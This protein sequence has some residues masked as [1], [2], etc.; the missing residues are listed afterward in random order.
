VSEERTAGTDLG[1]RISADRSSRSHAPAAQ[2]PKP[3][4][5]E[6]FDLDAGWPMEKAAND[7]IPGLRCL[8]RRRTRLFDFLRVLLVV[9][10]LFHQVEVSRVR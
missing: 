9:E 2:E 1:R 3:R 6:S 7:L 5:S 8:L 10:R 4:S